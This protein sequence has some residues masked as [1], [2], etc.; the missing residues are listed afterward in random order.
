M[1]QLEEIK[2]KINIVD[3]I[4]E[5]FP[6]KKTGRNFKALCPFH[7]EKTPSFIVSPE[8]QIWHCFGCGEGGDIFTFLMKMEGLEFSEALRILAQKT[9]VRLKS[10]VPGFSNK[11]E[12]LYR[13]NKI[14]ATLY[15]KILLE[16]KT[17]KPVL[18]YLKKRKIQTLTIKEFLIGLAPA[19]EKI[20]V[21]F[22]TK[23]GFTNQ[24]ILAAGLALVRKGKIIDLFRNRITFPL[25]NLYG[26]VVGFTGRAI[27]ENQM[28]KYLNTP[29]TLIFDKSR[30]FYD[31]NLAKDE[32][33]QQG[34]AILVEG[35]MDVLSVFQNGN[36]NVVC[37]S[38][39][40]LTDSQIDL[41][42]RFTQKVALAFDRDT[43][44]EK[45]SKRSIDLLVGKGMEVRLIIIPEGKD[46]DE[47]IRNNPKEWQKAVKKPIPVMDFYFQNVFDKIGKKAEDLEISD[48]KEISRELLPEIK[49]IPDKIE[50]ASYVQELANLLDLEDK[51][52]ADALKNLPDFKE[53]PPSG[54]KEDKENSGYIYEENKSLIG[55]LLLGLIIRFYKDVKDILAKLDL[56]AKD[57]QDQNLG[58]IYKKLQSFTVLNE[59]FAPDDFLKTLDSKLLDKAERGLMSIDF[60]YEEIEEGELAKE[61][62]S[63]IKRLKK[64]YYRCQKESIA[65]A[66]REAE[67]E[68]N[69]NKVR[70]L[71]TEFRKI[72]DK[73]ADRV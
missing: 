16:T 42:K 71:M 14:A 46:P 70:K 67:R 40:S 68:K 56:K 6:L 64:I 13:M 63:L 19:K 55:E 43:P 51:A 53:K 49:K 17:G 7:T 36:K 22:L 1:D 66:I 41:I 31:L 48:K 23:K 60:F 69:K 32:I 37:S 20:L 25:R 3:L 34:L 26:D 29:Q 15:Q 27:L 4:Q 61:V 21:D 57:F 62:E 35:Q 47:C 54:I 39:T 18:D 10:Q 72:V 2:S 65:K 30:I 11:K 58:T 28:P 5:Y 45:A 52:V 33:R 50:Q 24:E 59:V 8:R 38:G 12:R 73:E 9:G 44:G